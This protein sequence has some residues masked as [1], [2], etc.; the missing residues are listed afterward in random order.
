MSSNETVRLK[1]AQ[2][3]VVIPVYNEA[4]FIK[5]V[6]LNIP[7]WVEW[8]VV[9]D[10]ASTDESREIITSIPDTRIH[11]VAHRSNMGAGA[12]LITGYKKALSL[13]SQV[14]A[15]MAG[16]GQMD[17]A[18]LSRIVMPIA[19]GW[20]DYVKGNRFL[21]NKIAGKTI[22]D[23]KRKNKIPFFRGVGIRLFTFFTQLAAG[24]NDFGDSQC[25]FTAAGRKLLESLDLDSMTQRYGFPND[26]ILRLTKSGF[27]MAEVPVRPIYG[28]E[29]S[30][31]KPLRDLPSIFFQ[32]VKKMKRSKL[33]SEKQKR[34]IMLTT[35]FPRHEADQSGNFVA[36]LATEFAKT[37]PVTIIAPDSPCAVWTPRGVSIRRFRWKGWDGE[38]SLAYGHGIIENLREHPFSVLPQIP[39]FLVA[40]HS[41]AAAEIQKNDLIIS[42]WL[43][44]GSWLGAHFSRNNHH[45]AVAHGSDITILEYLPFIFRRM[46]LKRIWN[47]TGRIVAVSDNLAKRLEKMS[48][49]KWIKRITIM[50]M[51][52]DIKDFDDIR[53][54]RAD[55]QFDR[56]L[57]NESTNSN[58]KILNVLYMGR[59]IAVKGVEVLL[60]ALIHINE[61]KERCLIHIAGEG[62][63]LPSLKQ[64]VGLM[65]LP[66]V[67]HGC[68]SGKEK[69]K[70]LVISDIGVIPSI[71]TK[72]GVQ[73][74]LP[75]VLLELMASEIPVVASK[76]GGMP[77]VL[78]SDF[79]G[80][81]VTPGDP[82]ALAKALNELLVNPDKRKFLATN[83]L[84]S[85]KKYS[86]ERFAANC[87]KEYER[88]KL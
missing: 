27:S 71:I 11:L 1:S 74:G 76:S 33:I 85:V 25:G 10:D 48:S 88:D 19:E 67:F 62:P 55:R 73:D 43:I 79:D 63:L 68:V 29:K 26:M 50:P 49:K 36:R 72:R 22:L 35:S 45:V 42:H 51:P 56:S 78:R 16:D 61:V 69:E 4:L 40:M 31:I 3:A 8:I 14:I 13:G 41:A 83:A 58:N 81:L 38:H 21:H 84:E 23:G 32:I 28:N 65:N 5:D 7:E 20:V 86:F 77:D 9:V 24:R 87:L 57:F 60:K 17:P 6:L 47:N 37:L 64:T 15:V 53:R 75:L 66:V 52:I 59:L 18:D 12:A 70:L 80:L 2:V 54:K 46:V 30:G 44:P 34:I 39:G 82:A